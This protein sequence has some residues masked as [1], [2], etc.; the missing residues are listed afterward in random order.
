[1]RC[2]AS[3]E[4]GREEIALEEVRALATRD[5]AGFPGL[6]AWLLAKWRSLRERLPTAARLLE[7]AMDR[8]DRQRLEERWKLDWSV[9]YKQI[10]PGAPRSPVEISDEMATRFLVLLRRLGLVR[11]FAPRY[12]YDR[13]RFELK[14]FSVFRARPWPRLEAK[15]MLAALCLLETDEGGEVRVRED[16]GVYAPLLQELEGFDLEDPEQRRQALIRLAALHTAV[17]YREFFRSRFEMLR[18][19]EAYALH[20]GCRKEQLL[21]YFGQ[22]LPYFGPC[23][24]CDHCGIEERAPEVDPGVIRAAGALRELRR[25]LA[26]A[27]IEPSLF[28]ALDR[29]VALRAGA[30]GLAMLGRELEERPN[31]AVVQF[32]RAALTARVWDLSVDVTQRVQNRRDFEVALEGYWRR[33]EPG[34]AAALDG[35]RRAC[36]EAWRFHPAWWRRWLALWHGAVQGAGR[37][38]RAKVWA[39]L[40]AQPPQGVA[41]RQLARVLWVES[42]ACELGALLGAGAEG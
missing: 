31:D 1:M 19:V 33:G 37:Q 24:R 32:A 11:E 16:T 28:A 42:V 21:G 20:E 35:M 14:A 25:A 5:I 39:Q 6:G 41:G 15:P 3:E 17:R 27:A 26:Q 38:A 13:G 8:E 30:T 23:R 22:P 40:V 18:A 7:Q 9:K 4:D 2:L 34:S 29:L 36:A 10:K 12:E